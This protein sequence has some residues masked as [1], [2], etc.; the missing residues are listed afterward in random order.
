MKAWDTLELSNP[1]VAITKG[2]LGWQGGKHAFLRMEDNSS[3]VL[4]GP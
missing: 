1:A 3:A 4:P 2:A